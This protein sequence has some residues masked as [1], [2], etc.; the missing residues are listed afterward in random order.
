MYRI[1]SCIAFEHDLRYVGCA[2]MICALGSILGV[3]L[4]SRARRAE[5]LEKA[6]W[7]FMG[8]FIGGSAIWTTH[9]LAM[10]GYLPGEPAG[11]EP[12]LTMLSFVI[13]IATTTIGLTIAAYAGRSLLVEAG[14]IILGLGIAA[15]HYTG[16]AAYEIQG[17][18]IWDQNYVVASLLLAGLFGAL[19]TNRTARPFSRYCVHSGIV[20]L[21]LG[22]A[23]THFTAMAAVTAVLN[24]GEVMPLELF[25]PAIMGFGVLGVMLVLLTLAAATYLL[26]E[27]NTQAAVERYRHLSLHDPLTGLP[28]RAAFNEELDAIAKRPE[29][30]A[31]VAILSFD[32]DRFKEINDVHGHA[33]GDAVLRAIGSRL[34]TVIGEGEFA[35][36]VGGDEFIALTRNYYK[37][38]DASALAAR[39]LE[40]ICK[41][42]EWNGNT[43]SVG[44]SIGVSI[45]PGDA[46][47]VDDLVAQADVAMYRS[48]LSGTN[49]VCFY[50]S[51]MDQAARERNALAMDMRVG[52]QRR[53]FQLFYQRQNDTLTGEVIGFEVLL[54]WNHPVR[55]LVPP[56]EFIPIAERTG[57]IMELGEWVLRK[58]CEEAATWRNPLGIAVNIAA[59][60]LADPML[61]RR[62][63]DILQETG[64]AAERLELEITETGIIT[65]QQHALQIIGQL[66]GLGVKIAMDDYGTGYSSLSTLLSF[67]FD[68]IKIDRAFIEGVA[69]NP[70]S[71][72][73]VRSTL[74]LAGS[75]NIPVLAEGVETDE[76]MR[77]L[78]GEGCGQVQGY[79]FGRPGPREG[80]EAIVN[81]RVETKIETE[82]AAEPLV[83]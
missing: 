52:L 28:N 69:T 75:L 71:A 67:P 78:R 74:I 49:M 1:L 17:K 46:R 53:E 3:R 73:I 57:F 6:I 48:K 32:L 68:K 58:A 81:G 59:Q 72:A 4:F 13:A 25:S 20:A 12:S 45:Y 44:A 40:E 61:P 8:G 21:I 22:I 82:S 16:M 29:I 64:L 41:P 54:R 10:L 55:G 26:D 65:D 80:I 36:R 19:V 56:S 60:Q 7:L 76:H 23:S 24:P 30:D 70:Q 43:L 27:R 18:V 39:M 15:M 37:R 77:F 31:R 42:I 63:L 35:A 34:G 79:L 11:Y 2:V 5:G 83:A 66:K 14:G 47:T 38:A 51:S 9:F 62:V 50:D 33:A